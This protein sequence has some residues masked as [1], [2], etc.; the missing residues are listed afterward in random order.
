M[1]ELGRGDGDDRAHSRSTCGVAG[2]PGVRWAGG[3]GVGGAGGPRGDGDG[4]GG[5]RFMD[6][7]LSEL[8]ARSGVTLS[9]DTRSS[10]SKSA[11]FRRCAACSRFASVN[12]CEMWCSG[13]TGFST[14]LLD[15]SRTTPPS[16]WAFVPLTAWRMAAQPCFATDSSAS[17]SMKGS[18]ASS[19]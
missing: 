7:S 17:R 9:R 2:D 4:T 6:A 19:C 11:I 14:S 12:A 13:L 16:F 8:S 5:A 10:S 1:N 18:P 3:G 15:A